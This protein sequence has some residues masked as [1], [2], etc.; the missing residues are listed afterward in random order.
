[1][2]NLKDSNFVHLH[3]HSHYSLLD[4]LASID[5]L[6]DAAKK[7]G[8]SAL[9]LTDHGT[10]AGLYRFYK[11]CK[12]EG[13]KP[14]LGSE[15]YIS[16]DHLYKEK[17]ARNYHITILAKNKAGLKNIYKLS[18]IAEIYGKYRK[19]RID[20]DLIKHHKEGL[21]VTSGCP[22]GQL[23]QY[24][25]HEEMD[26]AEKLVKSYRDLLKDDYYIEIMMH[27]YEKCAHDQESKEKKV[28]DELLYMAKH[29][30]IKAICTNDVHYA[31]HEDAKYHDILLSM[32]TRD[33]IKNPDRF[34]LHSDEF[35]LK[36]KE[37]M[38]VFYK[39]EPDLF[40]NTVEIA[41][42]V[43]DE[44]FIEEGLDLLPPFEVPEGYVDEIDFLKKLATQGMK[45]KGFLD[46]PEYLERAKFEM[47]TIISCGYVKYFLILWDMINYAKSQK[48]RI[49]CGRGSAAGS[50]ILYVL[51]IVKLD[52]V[53]YK[54]L[55]ERFINPERIS[56]PDVD[57]DFDYNR[58][59]EMYDYLYDKY[60]A[61]HCAK[62]GTYNTFKA[63]AV[64]RY[65]SKALDIG[66]DWDK[67]QHELKKNPVIKP[68]MTKNSLD[69]A[70]YIAKLIPE[71]PDVTIKSALED[72]PDFAYAIK[73]YS[74]LLEACLKMEGKLSSAG[75]H[76]AG[77]VVCKEPVVEYAPLR[78][79]KGV[80]CTQYDK[81]EVENI[82]LLKFDLLALKTLT[83]VDDTLKLVKDRK[84]IEF[85]I[86]ALEPNDPEVLGLFNGMHRNMDN[87]G[88]FQFESYGMSSL[89]KEISIDSFEDLVA[90]NALYRPGP[91]KAQV[92]SLYASYKHG[93][94]EIKPLHPKM[95]ELL[96]DTYSVMVYQEDFMKVA[97]ELAGFTKGQSDTLR[98]GVGKK[99]PEI[100]KALRGDFVEG[101][102]KN[103]ISESIANKIFDQIV[104][105]GGYGFNRC[106][107]GDSEVLNMKDGNI[108]SLEYLEQE[109][110]MANYSKD[111]GDASYEFP[112]II[113]PSLKNG[114][115]VNDKVIDVFEVGERE[116]FEVELDNGVVLKCTM[117]HKFICSDYNSYTLEE[118]IKQDLDILYEDNIANKR[119]YL[120][121]SMET[122]G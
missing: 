102:M 92:P 91:M 61:D 27:K 19:P 80:I 6:V 117:D 60:G 13:I 2:C 72:S 110:Y 103:K 107:S 76:A 96:K 4:G 98:K 119:G 109:F 67:Y 78:N 62:I 35:Y 8:Q 83:I 97:Q 86:D 7:N 47:K 46:K 42:K 41:N 81:E 121:V 28:A 3:N 29:Y 87:R 116:L 9:A 66:K 105:F 79:A 48:I 73:Q 1:M 82:G 74:G 90:C 43:S 111:F 15:F 34:S 51:D 68:V 16:D 89:M 106:L 114:E 49:G 17:D 112:D 39:D 12:A 23:S 18:S 84:G 14:I 95:G 38:D 37:E 69:I 25:W 122:F 40:A 20:F 113:L 50:L 52:P 108:Y 24:I 64:V 101:C 115:I 65:A 44:E 22:S 59:D 53:K 63:R 75:V 31:N 55:F 11:K 100:L 21:I 70:D 88:I 33:H 56:P 10:C 94:K 58:R 57:I 118:I 99:K 36:T 32:Q 5:A 104:F 85:D 30:G 120:E 45:E 77:I 54:L 26:R 93:M 71:G